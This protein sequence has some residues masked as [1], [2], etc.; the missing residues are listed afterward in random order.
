ME[1]RVGST[2]A[3]T[4]G[5]PRS[6]AA[7]Q[8]ILAAVIPLIQK[9]GYDAFSI[10][11]LAAAAGVGKATIYR[12][13]ASKEDLVVEAAAHFVGGIAT[14]DLGSLRA[15]F[16]EVLR[17]NAALHFDAATPAFLSSLLAAM[18]RSPRIAAAVRGGFVAAREAALREVLG[19]AQARGELPADLDLELAVEVCA[20]PLLY[21]A[22]V[23]GRR[24]DER[25]L[26]ALADLLI[27]GLARTPET[28]PQ[29]GD[30]P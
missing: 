20:G 16:A 3:A 25:V 5:R 4:R 8:A 30:A 12:R 29:T 19:R 26:A 22:L 23:S 7:H 9:V 21:R 2:T 10:E 24:T 17:V 6:E 11:A 13:W 27:A 18:A 15:D 1:P 28:T 14:P